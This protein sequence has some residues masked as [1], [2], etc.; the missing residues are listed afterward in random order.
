M[1]VVASTKP[2]WPKTG[3]TW[4]GGRRFGIQPPARKTVAPS[5][6]TLRTWW[7]GLQ[8]QRIEAPAVGLLGVCSRLFHRGIRPSAMIAALV[9]RPP[10]SDGA[11]SSAHSTPFLNTLGKHPVL[12][13][14]AWIFGGD[15]GPGGVA[16]ADGALLDEQRERMSEQLGVCAVI[17]RLATVSNPSPCRRG[18]SSTLSPATRRRSSP[19]RKTRRWPRRRSRGERKR[20]R[21]NPSYETQK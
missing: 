2:Q 18:S 12:A 1:R 14:V 16:T 10:L 13:T 6:A 21:V 20:R 19:A 5:L 8:V 11:E 15:G 17:A 7:G 3:Q 9:R 4:V